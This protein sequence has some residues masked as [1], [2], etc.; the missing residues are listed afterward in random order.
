MNQKELGEIRR[1]IRP[2]HNS[3]QHIYGCYVNSNK[4]M[5]AT[6]DGFGYKDL[7]EYDCGM[8]QPEI[9]AKKAAAGI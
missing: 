7:Y 3:I 1:R 2:E 6:L 5:I 4:E 9:D 8:W